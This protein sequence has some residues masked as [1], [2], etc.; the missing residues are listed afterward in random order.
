MG[1]VRVVKENITI[2]YVLIPNIFSFLIL[3]C[4]LIKIT[5][6]F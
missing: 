5:K 3:T 2:N 4:K 6:I 1:Q